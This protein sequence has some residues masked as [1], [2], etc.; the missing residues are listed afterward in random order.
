LSRRSGSKGL[1]KVDMAVRSILAPA[2][3]TGIPPPN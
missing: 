1:S 2:L 3:R